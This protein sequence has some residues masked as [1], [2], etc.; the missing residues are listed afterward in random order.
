MDL[1]SYFTH[2]GMIE[3]NYVSNISLQKILYFAQGFYLAENQQT[4]LF[5]DKIF[6]W[7]FGPVVKN[8]Y[9]DL[10]YFGNNHIL[11]G[12][13][14][15]LILGKKYRTQYNNIPINYSNFLNEIWNTFKDY[16][17]FELVEL[18]HAEGSP[19]HEIFIQNNRDL[20][21]NKNIEITKDS[22]YKYFSNLN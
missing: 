7:K 9:H 18:T 13:E 10:K 17:P 14:S 11:F 8:I 12:K 5:L 4:P 19:W 15:D 3:E 1:C 16:E 22:M 20:G 21:D 2:K 6:A